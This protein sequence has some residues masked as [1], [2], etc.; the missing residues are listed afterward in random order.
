ML[1]YLPS[2]IQQGRKRVLSL[3]LFFLWKLC[4][5]QKRMLTLGHDSVFSITVA[6]T[7]TRS[8][9]KNE[10]W[11]HRVLVTDV[12][13]PGKRRVGNASCLTRARSRELQTLRGRGAACPGTAKSL[14][15]LCLDQEM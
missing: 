3:L 1:G 5:L 2:P 8:F 11:K 14:Q 13:L 7:R 15:V 6:S 12:L 4:L 10:R 9:L